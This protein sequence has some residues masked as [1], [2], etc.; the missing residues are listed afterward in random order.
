MGARKVIFVSSAVV[1]S[2]ALAVGIGLEEEL[3]V[4]DGIGDSGLSCRMLT[5]GLGVSG[6]AVRVA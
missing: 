6:Y 4:T 1:D 5:R 2:S 3:F